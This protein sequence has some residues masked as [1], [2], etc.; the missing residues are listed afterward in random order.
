MLKSFLTY[1]LFL[2]VFLLNLMPAHGQEIDFGDYYDYSLTIEEQNPGAD[3][4]FGTI[5]SGS[6]TNSIG[7]DNA[8]VFTITG[9]KYLDVFLTVTADDELLL[10]GNTGCIGSLTCSIDFTLEAAYANRGSD[11][12][13]QAR[14]I[15]MGANT[16]TVQ[17]PIKYRSDGTPPAPPPTPVYEGYDPSVFNETAYLY[18][19]GALSVGNV[20]TGS[21][22]AEINITII[23]D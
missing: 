1:L 23:Y 14:T 21:Y 13:G 9:V 4:V 7:I 18:L 3:F 22:S 8:L 6:G 20:D 2:P 5:I 16:G 10:N 17:F 19:Y 12:I 15:A 11:N